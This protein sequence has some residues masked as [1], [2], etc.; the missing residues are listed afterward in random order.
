MPVPVATD[1]LQYIMHCI[2]CI[3]IMYTMYFTLLQCILLYYS[4]LHY[5]CIVHPNMGRCCSND[6]VG[7]GTD[8]AQTQQTDDSRK[9]DWLQTG[10]YF[11]PISG[12]YSTMW[13]QIPPRANIHLW[14]DHK[15][16]WLTNIWE[17]LMKSR[18]RQIRKSWNVN[19]SGCFA[20]LECFVDKTIDRRATP[21]GA[22]N[23]L[24][25]QFIFLPF[26]GRKKYGNIFWSQYLL[27]QIITSLTFFVDNSLTF[28]A[29]FLICFGDNINF[30]QQ[31][32]NTIVGNAW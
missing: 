30:L 29:K 9:S 20:L 17:G 2:L 3:D 8:G 7:K 27:K 23:I 22:L 11:S 13:R 6:L 26:F 1:A 28:L 15:Y 19:Y 18:N 21:G 31:N 14:P 16:G 4:A 25:R 32:M 24:F 5:N 10:K 12:K